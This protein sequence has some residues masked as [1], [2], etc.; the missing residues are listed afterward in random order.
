MALVKY[1][2]TTI[3][4]Q[5][6]QSLCCVAI[7]QRVYCL[8]YDA[9]LI[10]SSRPTHSSCS[11]TILQ[12]SHRVLLLTTLL[13][14]TMLQVQQRF[15]RKQAD[16]TLHNASRAGHISPLG[17]AAAA[18][19]ATALLCADV[20]PRL[21]DHLLHQL[22]QTQSHGMFPSAHCPTTVLIATLTISGR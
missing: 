1:Q 16:W 13:L 20:L 14:P 10:N 7:L 21:L 2:Y 11:S 22:K 15:R 19:P 8:Y 9:R 5:N 6:R 3:H 12:R 17:A 4:E 18:Q